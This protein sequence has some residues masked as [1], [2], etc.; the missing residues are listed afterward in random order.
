MNKFLWLIGLP[1]IVA[2][3][4]M[5]VSS[6]TQRQRVSQALSVVA[7]PS[8]IVMVESADSN[9]NG[10]R[11]AHPPIRQTF[12]SG[13]YRL[14]ISTEDNWKTPLTQAKLFQGSTVL[15]EK[16]LPHQYG[17]KFVL[18]G[19]QG[20]VLLL[21]EFINVASPHAIT[22]IDIKG[23]AIAQ[24]SVKAIQTTLNLSTADLTKQ[25][26]TG[27]WISAAPTLNQLENCATVLT[28]GTTLSID[29]ETGAIGPR[30]PSII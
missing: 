16:A 6:F 7:Q 10:D 26:T 13:T 9:A 19:T 18:I 21:D 11:L 1:V 23:Q 20:N 24:H 2:V 8:T 28:G 25:A 30:D 17:P 5:L 29:L 12:T 27:W 22:L 14:V 4:S 3:I 15:W